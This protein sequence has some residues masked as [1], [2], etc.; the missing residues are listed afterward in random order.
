MKNKDANWKTLR[1]E[2]VRQTKMPGVWHMRRGGFFVRAR[3]K[4]PK[5]SKLVE[6][7]RKLP[8]VRD[9]V[10]AHRLLQQAL[11]EVSNPPPVRPKLH[12]ATYA[13]SLLERKINSGKLNSPESRYVL[14]LVLEKHLLPA[15]GDLLV[16]EIRRA[17]IV[18]WQ[19][20]VAKRIRA[21]EI[22]PVTGNNWLSA[23]ITILNAYYIEY[24]L[25]RNPTKGVERFDT[26][27]HHTYTE[28]EPNSMTD[29][30]AKAF[31]A[32]VKLHYPQHYAMLL[33][34]IILGLRPSHLIPLRW[35]GAS[36]DVLW[37]S[38]KLLIRR[39]HTRGQT[40][41]RTKTGKSLSIRL[42]TVLLDVLR[43]HVAQLPAEAVEKTDLLFPSPEDGG[44]MHR[45]SL[46][47]VFDRA[48]KAAGIKKK[49]TP[50]SMRRTF[51]NLCDLSRVEDTV[52]RSIAGH[53]SVEMANRYR[54]PQASLQTEALGKLLDR[55]GF[56]PKPSGVSGGA[57]NPPPDSRGESLVEQAGEAA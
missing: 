41:E 43:E 25:E 18:A 29:E 51:Y 13:V 48:R 22:T 26:S 45:A 54:T 36:P 10:E 37:D 53:A 9:V 40:M 39:S 34:G 15:F 3:V 47:Y 44:E 31:L 30:E 7:A 1:G 28:E 33:T 27:T 5:T 42:P 52:A 46:N 56:G 16:E 57:Q 21:G 38:G 24:E 14:R 35:Q 49:L 23:L 2:E 4:H 17:D 55:V 32:A 8:E 6:V 12:F 20:N 19:D 50:R 11:E